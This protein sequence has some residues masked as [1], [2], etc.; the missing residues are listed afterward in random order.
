ML[1]SDREGLVGGRGP[2]PAPRAASSFADRTES[3]L[4]PELSSPGRTAQ[5]TP[6]PAPRVRMVSAGTHFAAPVA[7]GP[8]ARAAG[9]ASASGRRA[10]A[11]A[12]VSDDDNAWVPRPVGARFAP[13]KAGAAPG[14]AGSSARERIERQAS[15][16]PFDTAQ[17]LIA[18]GCA[19]A[20]PVPSAPAS[21]APASAA[22]AAPSAPVKPMPDATPGRLHPAGGTA[23]SPAP[24]RAVPVSPA[25]TAAPVAAGGASPRFANSAA[26]SAAYAM[27]RH[28]ESVRNAAPASPDPARSVPV[29]S[30]ANMRPA[31]PG[32]GA[33]GRD[34]PAPAHPADAAFDAAATG[35]I[36]VPRASVAPA[37][38]ASVA[39]RAA[40]APGRAYCASASGSGA[41]PPRG[42]VPSGSASGFQPPEPPRK[43]KGG[44]L[45]IVLIVVGVA[46]LLV[47]GGLFIK[48]QIGYKQAE[49]TYAGLQQY[50]VSADSGDGVPDVDFDGL[51]A[52]NPDIVG[53]IYAPGTP[54]NYPVVQTDDNTTY[55][56]KLFDLSGNGSGTI[57]M[58]MDDTA[59]G[60]V[61]QQTTLYGHHMNDGKMFKVVDNTLDQASF[62]AFPFVYYITPSAT[63]KLRPLMTAQVEDT[64]VD[65]RKTNFTGEGESLRAYL[66]DM[67]AHAKAQADDAA[68]RIE[69]TDQ[70]MS[71]VTCA[72]EIIPRTTRAVM[73][74]TV[75]EVTARQ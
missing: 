13:S 67:L 62:D 72:G 74:L 48:A 24:S 18:A 66:E 60:M 4:F 63:Y 55:L 11:P 9:E 14:S 15:A 49:S 46:L 36:P 54:I 57:F 70:V 58:D 3:D 51:A 31:A 65:A 75:E 6:V 61:D 28:P 27:T 19:P 29:G 50:A 59:P 41:V 68:A 26:S 69:D 56:T 38:Q 42:P 32:F 44:A 35:R 21:F 34:V 33:P 53:W 12:A 30:V 39:A 47:A 22:P 25:P 45:S 10:P 73:V 43:K 64:Y 2:A 71:L 5:T 52:I 37:V 17:F 1:H 16:N 7:D 40:A 23:A 8:G 20:V